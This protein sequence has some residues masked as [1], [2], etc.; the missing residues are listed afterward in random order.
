MNK[1]RSI[2]GFG[3]LNLRNSDSSVTVS[4]P[5]SVHTLSFTKQNK[6]Q[7]AVTGL[8]HQTD[9]KYRP[10]IDC[11][12]SLC[13]G[14]YIQSLVSLVQLLNGTYFYVAP[15]YS[16]GNTQ[17]VEYEC[18]LSTQNVRFEQLADAQVGQIIELSFTGRR[19]IKLP[20]HLSKGETFYIIDQSDNTFVDQSGNKLTLIA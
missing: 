12:I 9:V 19:P 1:V 13:D 10:R 16:V 5:T 3:S 6:R 4:F 15:Q 2:W 18:V 8:L 7:T 11:T 14:S 20:Y 17:N